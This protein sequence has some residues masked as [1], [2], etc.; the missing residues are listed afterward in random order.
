MQALDT[1][2][3][4]STYNKSLGCGS[5][6]KGCGPYTLNQS[7]L[8]STFTP[9]CG[10][11]LYVSCEPRHIS[12]IAVVFAYISSMPVLFLHLL[13][14]STLFFSVCPQAS[15]YYLKPSWSLA[16]NQKM[17]L[18]NPQYPGYSR[19]QWK[20]Q[21]QITKACLS[22]SLRISHSL[23]HFILCS[24]CILF[25]FVISFIY[26]F[27]ILSLLR[28]LFGTVGRCLAHQISSRTV[29]LPSL[30]TTVMTLEC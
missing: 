17:T 8:D 24:I 21:Q 22:K 26:F 20:D 12:Y 3:I 27:Q 23:E 30:V 1:V 14:S 18:V 7:E 10:F 6:R 2:I 29:H 16:T 28:C 15:S 9:Q 19:L 11:T 13:C 5:I 25:F 4:C